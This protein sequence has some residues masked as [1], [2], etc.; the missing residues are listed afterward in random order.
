MMN[1]KYGE[2][3]AEQIQSLKTQMRKRIFFLLLCVDKD[4]EEQYKN[5]DVAS[6]I[7]NLIVEFN[8]LNELL[9][10]PPELLRVMS[11]LLAAK[12]EYGRK[13]FSFA[14][15]RRLILGAGAEVLKIKEE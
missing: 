2:C 8:G 3:P 10:Y 4:T 12:Q 11:L 5:I 7:E 15:Y 1:Y 9:K 6:A 13:E 14:E